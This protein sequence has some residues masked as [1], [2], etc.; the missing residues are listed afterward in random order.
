[1]T[2]YKFAEIARPLAILLIPVTI[3]LYQLLDM[4]AVAVGWLVVNAIILWIARCPICGTSI[5]WDKKS[6]RDTVMAVPHSTCT[7]CGH[8]LA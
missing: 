8:N 1:M 2:R 6:L 7:E 4:T 5:Y 3:V